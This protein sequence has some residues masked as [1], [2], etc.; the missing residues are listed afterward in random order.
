MDTFSDLVLSA[1]FERRFVILEEKKFERKKE[2]FSRL[3]FVF[4]IFE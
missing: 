1:D 4:L 2:T 3:R